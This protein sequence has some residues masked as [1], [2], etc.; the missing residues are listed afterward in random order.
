MTNLTLRPPAPI[1]VTLSKWCPV[2]VIAKA[3]LAN[4]STS[5]E[6]AY[7]QERQFLNEATGASIYPTESY[8]VRNWGKA[9]AGGRV[10]LLQHAAVNGG[11]SFQVRVSAVSGPIPHSLQLVPPIRKHGDSEAQR[12]PWLSLGISRRTYYNRKRAGVL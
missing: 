9:P 11:R 2:L 4:E 10:V 7:L 3:S 12:K 8:M 5:R 1:H 6:L